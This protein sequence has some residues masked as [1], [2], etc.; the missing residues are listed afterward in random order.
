MEFNQDFAQTLIDLKIDQKAFILLVDTILENSRL[1]YSKNGLMIDEEAPIY[2]IIRAFRLEEYNNR[3][4]ELKTEKIAEDL[5]A[6]VIKD[7]EVE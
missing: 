3:L 2:S 1:N 4:N 5:G 6:K 7:E